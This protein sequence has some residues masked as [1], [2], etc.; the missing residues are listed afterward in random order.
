MLLGFLLGTSWDSGSA[1]E[2]GKVDDWE[3]STSSAIVVLIGDHLR[4]GER[5]LEKRCHGAIYVSDG[6]VFAGARDGGMGGDVFRAWFSV[7][8]V[9]GRVVVG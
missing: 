5:S 3:T 9:C 8:V 6:N 4:P 7:G 2:I 1:I